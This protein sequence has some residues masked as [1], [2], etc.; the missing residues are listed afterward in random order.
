[1]LENTLKFFFDLLEQNWVTVLVFSCALTAIMAANRYSNVSAVA[2]ML[3]IILYA[4]VLVD[5]LDTEVGEAEPGSF[6]D[7]LEIY[8]ILPAVLLL[9]ALPHVVARALLDVIRSIISPRIKMRK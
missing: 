8:E 9:L 7:Q 6:V 1:M 4:L 3:C 2:Y 5:I